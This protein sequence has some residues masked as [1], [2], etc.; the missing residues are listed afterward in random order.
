MVFIKMRTFGIRGVKI[1]D[2]NLKIYEVHFGKDYPY[3]V[4]AE[5]MKE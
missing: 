1:M 5:I 4:M 3:M 2:N